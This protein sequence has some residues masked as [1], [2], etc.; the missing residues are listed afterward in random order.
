MQPGIRFVA[1]SSPKNY[2][3]VTEVFAQLDAA[4]TSREHWKILFIS[5]MGFFTD[6]YDLLVFG[7]VAD[8]LGRKKIYGFEVLVLAAGAV[9]SAFSPSIWWLIG[10][11]VILGFGIGGDY[12]VSATIMSV[13]AGNRRLMTDRRHFLGSISST[14]HSTLFWS[15][16]E[17]QILSS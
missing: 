7:R 12:P 5:G 9:A 16:T 6:A 1:R 15:F 4:P 8:R 13:Y 10:L 14:A 17:V 2:G 3:Q 11:R